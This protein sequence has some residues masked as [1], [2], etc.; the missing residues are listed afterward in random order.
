MKINF[1]CKNFKP[2][3]TFCELC[4]LNKRYVD[5]QNSDCK[6]CFEASEFDIKPA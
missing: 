5:L 2:G 4:V 3:Y 1:N 6:S